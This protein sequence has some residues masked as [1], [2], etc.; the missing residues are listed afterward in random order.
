MSD[1]QEDLRAMVEAVHIASPTQFTV[2]GTAHEV[3]PPREGEVPLVKALQN[4]L[5][6][7]LY[8]RS[9]DGAAAE[10]AY[11]DELSARELIA[12]LSAAN[13]GRGTWEPG[14]VIQGAADEGRVPVRKEGLTLWVTPEQFRS[15]G[16]SLRPGHRCRVRIGKELR[17]LMLGFYL[18][19]GDGDE[20]DERD[21]DDV[22]TR[23]YFHVRPSGAVPFVAGLT[24]ALNQLHVPFRAKVVNH[25]ALYPRADAGVLYLGKRHYPRVAAAL[26]A[27]YDRLAP[28]LEPSVPM[29]TRPLA[30]GLGLAEDPATEESFGQHRC[31]L[32]TD[33]LWRAYGAGRHGTGERL[34]AVCQSLEALGL[35]PRRLYLQPRSTDVYVALGESLAPA[36][37]APPPEERPRWL[38]EREH[39]LDRKDK[40]TRARVQRRR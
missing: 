11:F 16:G 14:W 39:R 3:A 32:I 17:E 7:R 10:T 38:R 31:R 1:T 5:Y 21:D 6:A 28:H 25:P 8:T 13:C 2:A 19:I 30:P 33:A 23:F 4:E 29:F 40:K 12:A 18:V 37:A 27:L 9:Q 35:D 22:M 15:P 20:R 24:G 26:P 36:A 34:A